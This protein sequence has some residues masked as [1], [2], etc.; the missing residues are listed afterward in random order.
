MRVLGDIPAH[1]VT[2]DDIEKVFEEYEDARALESDDQ[3][4]PRAT[5]RHLQLRGDP[6]TRMGPHEQPGALDR[7]PARRPARGATILRDRGGRGDRRGRPPAANGAARRSPPTTA[8]R[9]P[10]SRS[11]RRTSSSPN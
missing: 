9:W 4:D 8:T 1:R 11:R 7:A 2:A 3:Q 5:P 10:S 6:K